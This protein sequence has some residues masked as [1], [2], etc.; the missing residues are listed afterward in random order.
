MDVI[1]IYTTISRILL[2]ILINKTFLYVISLGNYPLSIVNQTKLYFQQ[3]TQYLLDIIHFKF[4]IKQNI[5]YNNLY[6]ITLG[7]HLIYN[8]ISWIVLCISINTI[9]CTAYVAYLEYYFEIQPNKTYIKYFF[10]IQSNK[11]YTP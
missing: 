7:Y 2:C 5:I 9:F 4:L 3:L 1:S 10:E 6:L 11:T 8:I